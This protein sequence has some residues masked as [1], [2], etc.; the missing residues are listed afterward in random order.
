MKVAERLFPNPVLVGAASGEAFPDGL[1]GG[2]MMGK[3]HGPLLLVNSAG[4]LVPA[5]DAYLSANADDDRHA[6]TRV[7]GPNAV[8]DFVIRQ[9]T[10]AIL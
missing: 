7:G 8:T 1:S 10:T 5:V 3:D 4:D 6:A 9:M 2:A